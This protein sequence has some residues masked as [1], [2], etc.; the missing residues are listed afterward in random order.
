MSA[1]NAVMIGIPKLKEQDVKMEWELKIMGI[2]SGFCGLIFY[3]V[4]FIG[5]LVPGVKPRDGIELMLCSYVGAMAYSIYQAVRFKM[6][7]SKKQ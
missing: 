7:K 5:W 6:K 3:T 2:T 4:C 1:F